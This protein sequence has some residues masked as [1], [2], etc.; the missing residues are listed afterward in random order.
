MRS[1]GTIGYHSRQDINEALPASL[2][3]ISH[4]SP[5]QGAE[6]DSCF[7][8]A[9]SPVS[10]LDMLSPGI[11]FFLASSPDA[12]YDSPLHVKPHCIICEQSATIIY[13][14]VDV[15]ITSSTVLLLRLVGVE[16]GN[17]ASLSNR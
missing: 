10:V 13:S 1:N 5:G 15:L 14:G 4:T 12:S 7:L 8:L 3:H 6:A 11:F 16:P 17:E 2:F 9:R